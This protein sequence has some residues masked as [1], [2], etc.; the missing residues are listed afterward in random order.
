MTI[1]HSV[2]QNDRQ[3]IINFDGLLYVKCYR[4]EWCLHQ[5]KNTPQQHKYFKNLLEKGITLPG[6][7]FTKPVKSKYA[8][9][10]NL[11]K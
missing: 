8:E 6:C 2:V 4:S 10:K 1:R 3:P 11:N 5:L 9:K 7:I